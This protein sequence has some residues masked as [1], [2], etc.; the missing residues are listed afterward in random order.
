[1]LPVKDSLPISLTLL[2]SGKLAVM[3]EAPLAGLMA[4]GLRGES[5]TTQFLHPML[6]GPCQHPRSTP[7]GLALKSIGEQMGLQKDETT[8]FSTTHSRINQ[9]TLSSINPPIAGSIYPRGT[10]K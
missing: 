5:A 4:S 1:M 2:D 10:R 9:L 6:Y 3:I 8:A 7:S